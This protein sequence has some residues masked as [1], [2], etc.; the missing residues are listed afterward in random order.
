MLSVGSTVFREMNL[1]ADTL[2]IRF[3]HLALAINTV[4]AVLFSK[5][6]LSGAAWAGVADDLSQIS[7]EATRLIKVRRELDRAPEEKDTRGAPPAMVDSSKALASAQAVMD[8]QFKAQQAMFKETDAL[9]KAELQNRLAV[10][11][12]AGQAGIRN[13]EEVAL[14]RKAAIDGEQQEVLGSLI[15]QQAALQRY[16]SE[17]KALFQDNEKGIQD[18]AKFE[19]E[20]QQRVREA[21][22]QL[23]VAMANADTA[24]VQSGAAVLAATKTQ[25]L[26][27]L[28]DAV[29]L[30]KADF[31]LQRTFYSQAPGFIGAT[32]KV[33]EKALQLLEAETNLRATEINNQIRDEERRA[34]A[35]IALD[36]EVNTKRMEI[37]RQFP[38][39]FE[40]QMQD[41]VASNAFSVSQII[42]S[43]TGGVANAIVTG[44][45]FIKQTTQATEVAVV[46]AALNAGTQLLAEYALRAAAEVGFATASAASVGAINAAKN[47]MIIAGETVTAGATV[48]IWAGASTALLG[49]F[50]G[51]KI[52]L[53]ALYGAIIAGLTAVGTAIMGVLTAIG[54]AIGFTGFGAPL[55]GAIIAGVVAIGIALAAAG[56]IKFAKGG[57]VTGPTLGMIGEAGPEAVVPLD[58][59]GEMRGGGNGQAIDNKIYLDGRL[60]AQLMTDQTPGALRTMGII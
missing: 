42:S 29:N 6:A 39:F 44:Q 46:Q 60:F 30:A 4:A 51:L 59:L 23:A 43:W 57:V 26:Q 11:D 12:A 13:A 25:K 47:S 36:A 17:R 5:D 28:Q 21:V 19:V 54:E 53:G 31:D 16:N 1:A 32:N 49:M 48:G 56:A 34:S 3:T 38:T 41:V 58:R 18:R 27:P 33:R 20:A 15:V 37:T 8:E 52:S 45:D 7:S 55:A 24:Q 35:F 10:L 2:A 14:A 40:K 22:N 50:I 9:N